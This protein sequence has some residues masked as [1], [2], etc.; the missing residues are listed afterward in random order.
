MSDQAA[1]FVFDTRLDEP[2]AYRGVRRR[3]IVSFLLDYFFI[4][5]L[6]IPA[7]IIVFLLGILT[8]GLGWMLFAV[9][10]PLVA[11][12]YVGF[13]MGSRGHATPGMRLAGIKIERL[14]GGPIDPLFAILH[15]VLFWAGNVILTPAILL[16]GL[17]TARKQLAHD[18]LLGTVMIRDE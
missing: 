2:R 15:G 4:A 14:D 6:T 11:A 16:F 1:G 13:T 12:I 8:L 7:S 10:V 9:L 18:L 5:L 17:L 3:R